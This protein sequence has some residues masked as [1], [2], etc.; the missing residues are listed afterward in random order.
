[1]STTMTARSF[2]APGAAARRRKGW[3]SL[4]LVLGG[5]YFFLPLLATFLFSLHGKKGA[6]SFIAYAHVFRDPEFLHTFSFSLEMAV[7]TIAA[8]LALMIPTAI[9]VNL[10]LPRARALIEVFALLPFVIPPIVLVFGLIRMYSRPPVMLVTSPVLL[11]AGYVVL[12]FPYIF[13]SVDAGLRAIDLRV[14]TEAAQSLGARW[15]T[16]LFRVVLPNIR[17]SVL[18]AAFLTFSIVVGELTLAVMLAWP[19]FGPYMALVG[20]DL[21]YEPAALAVISFLLTWG[22]LAVIQLA[23]RGGRG[24]GP[25]AGGVH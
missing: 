2:A 21:A 14:L 16:T 7:V 17:V 10:R 13:R 19:A 24:Q 22:S 8:G 12:S 11:I 6:L 25:T 4:W 5:L 20:R 23:S 9:W 1:M 18:S 15:S 3:S